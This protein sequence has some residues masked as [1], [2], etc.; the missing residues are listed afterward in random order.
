MSA[1]KRK[2]L[3]IASGVGPE[4]YPVINIPVTQSATPR[5]RVPIKTAAGT[6]KVY[7]SCQSFWCLGNAEALIAM[8][9]IDQ[10]WLPGMPGNNKSS[11]SVLFDGDKRFMVVGSCIQAPG[12]RDLRIQKRGKSFEVR[13]TMTE[14]Q[15]DEQQKH[16]EAE[17][18]AEQNAMSQ[19]RPEPM[20][21]EHALHSLKCTVEGCLRTL[22]QFQKDSGCAFTDESLHRIHTAFEMLRNAYAGAS[23]VRVVPRYQREGNVIHWPGR[24]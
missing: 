22:K 23:M 4:T 20:T 6:V 21:P 5:N 10:S 17:R 13:V 1:Q 24:S 16:E 2:C 19:Y 14:A 9:L 8:G 11:T 3:P 12:T 18:Q 7:V 15:I